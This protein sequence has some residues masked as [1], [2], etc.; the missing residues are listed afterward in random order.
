MDQVSMT[1]SALF[2]IL[3]ASLLPLTAHAQVAPQVV[4][5][6]C[7]GTVS[8]TS[9]S[10][11]WQC[12][13]PNNTGEGDLTG[14]TVFYTDAGAETN[15]NG[16]TASS[17]TVAGT[18]T[19]DTAGNTTLKSNAPP[20]TEYCQG[21][22]GDY[23]IVRGIKCVFVEIIIGFVAG[24]VSLLGKLLD[25]AS[26]AFSFAIQYTI[27]DFNT[28][29]QIVA[30]PVAKAWAVFRD[31]ANILIIGL[32]VFI[33]ISI[34][35]GLQEYGQKKL[36]ARVIIVSVLINFSF[37]FTTIVINASN[38]MASAVLSAIP[39]EQSQTSA[40]GVVDIGHQLQT[41]MGVQ[42]AFDTRNTLMKQYNN[43]NSTFA[44]VLTYAFFAGLFTIGATLVLGYGALLLFSRF[45]ILALVLL[46]ISSLAFATYL[47]PSLEESAWG[48]WRH[49]L[50][51]NA[52]FA[53]LM[54]VFL[55]VSV[56]I[57]Q[58][59]SK[60]GI[61][62]QGATVSFAGFASNPGDNSIWKFAF[63]Y[64]IILGVL[65]AGMYVASQL[66]NGVSKR[67]AFGAA[68]L[69]GAWGAGIGAWAGRNVIGRA[70]DKRATNLGDKAKEIAGTIAQKQLKGDMSWK[71]DQAKLAKVMRQKSFATD[72]SKKTYDARNT[73]PVG[74]LLKQSGIPSGLAQGTKKN[75]ADAAHAEAEK[76]ARDAVSTAMGE[77]AMR[78]AASLKHQDEKDTARAVHDSTQ[79]NIRA[80]QDNVRQ[81]RA[82]AEEELRL[83]KREI[84]K[85]EV[86]HKNLAAKLPGAQPKERQDLINKMDAQTQK[87]N[88]ARDAA[89]PFE[90]NLKEFDK[91]LGEL[92]RQSRDARD[93]LRTNLSTIAK[94]EDQ[95]YKSLAK[96][97]A[98]MVK[99]VATANLGGN[100]LSG[101]I[102]RATG[103]RDAQKVHHTETIA[104][105]R[106]RFK[107]KA[108]E[109]KGVDD[110]NAKPHGEEHGGAKKDDHGTAEKH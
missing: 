81:Q 13:I 22:S 15:L 77:K 46:P 47:A 72:M 65:W 107:D 52:F 38:L 30:D 54:M 56:T 16:T 80:Q 92:E 74:G 67:L 68:G 98:D 86:E 90:R 61:F 57:A 21:D 36:I 44:G 101:L 2:G 26:S 59:V 63:A 102:G 69:G 32:F 7:D 12:Y 53:P 18:L 110:Y 109:K 51:R 43:V 93:A 60:A 35:L 55:F 3:L 41:Y 97:Q 100:S 105:S 71:D 8:A 78:D 10:G 31:L 49:E 95:T 20:N 34:I 104:A 17:D 103:I 88:A 91:S 108:E 25:F 24:F 73:A 19:T 85:E 94:R 89:L 5:D 106:L 79:Q 40:T 45:I 6:K 64:I 50:I 1:K 76:A 99:G 70:Y 87:I 9:Q 14:T 48:K 23:A 83:K 39:Q 58:S 82:A 84:E 11:V 4:R 37:L 33:A 42:T 62:G 28:W 66:A 29:Y 27:Q 75:Y 96:D